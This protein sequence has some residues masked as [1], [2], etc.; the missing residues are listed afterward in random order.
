MTN[1][2]TRATPKKSLVLSNNDFKKYLPALLKTNS[3]DLIVLKYIFE[4]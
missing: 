3:S 1:L 2:S 4:R